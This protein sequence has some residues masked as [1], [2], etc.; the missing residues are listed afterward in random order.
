M[1]LMG[2]VG[3]TA[4]GVQNEGIRG[5]QYTIQYIRNK[6]VGLCSFKQGGR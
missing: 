2:H 6:G 5:C 4:G 1:G 3:H